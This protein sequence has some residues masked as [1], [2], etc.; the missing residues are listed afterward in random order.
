MMRDVKEILYPAS[1]NNE[2]LKGIIFYN[3]NFREFF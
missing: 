2:Y 3:F 1:N